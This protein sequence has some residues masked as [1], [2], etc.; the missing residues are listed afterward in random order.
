M[1]SN[2]NFNPVIIIVVTYVDVYTH[3]HIC[4]HIVVA[5]VVQFLSYVGLFGTPGLQH[6]RLP[7][8]S[9]SPGAYSYS[10]PLSW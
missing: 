4:I 1:Y 6:A 7:Y 10:C 5:V 8:P 2:K 9:P 3:T